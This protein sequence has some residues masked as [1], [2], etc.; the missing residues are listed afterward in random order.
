MTPRAEGTLI[1]FIE[2]KILFT[3]SDCRSRRGTSQAKAAQHVVGKRELQQHSADLFLAADHQPGEPHATRPGVRALGFAAFPVQGHGV[4]PAVGVPIAPA[5][6]VQGPQQ[7]GGWRAPGILLRAAKPGG[8]GSPRDLSHGVRGRRRKM[9]GG[10]D[11]GPV[12]APADRRA[13]RPGRGPFPQ[14]EAPTGTTGG[15]RPSFPA[16]RLGRL[17]T[18]AGAAPRCQQNGR[19]R[20]G[21][22]GRPHEPASPRCRGGR[23]RR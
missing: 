7:R 5:R 22:V 18:P 9:V 10:R 2:H 17:F 3:T 20:R 14:A 15:R 16:W 21:R 13:G 11:C 1:S 6:W 19:R 12:P 4:A 23:D 8:S